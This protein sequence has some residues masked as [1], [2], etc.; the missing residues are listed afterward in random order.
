M[1]LSIRAASKTS[2]GN[3][4]R[5]ARNTRNAKGVED[6]KKRL[7][8]NVARI[9][10]EIVHTELKT[11]LPGLVTITGVELAKDI[12]HA[13]VRYTVL[14]DSADRSA[15]ARRLKQVS[16]FVQREV[17]DRLHLRVTP[18]MRFEYDRAG[19]RGSRVLDLLADLEKE[20][21]SSTDSE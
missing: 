16:S 14:G 3:E 19:E 4:A 11:P 2:T 13:R 5:L 21:G 10:A 17:A 1:A 9:T 15:V 6:R 12:S 7:E 18:Q 20:D 8:D